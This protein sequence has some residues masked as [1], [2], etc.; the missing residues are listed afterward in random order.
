MC[1]Y[2]LNIVYVPDL[3]L[4]SVIPT[5]VD[6]SIETINTSGTNKLLVHVSK[7][8]NILFWLSKWV[9]KAILPTVTRI[10]GTVGTTRVVYVF[11]LFIITLV[12]K[13]ENLWQEY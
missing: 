8:S 6:L 3:F 11:S 9:F 7:T 12:R 1:S 10:L 13:D 5:S 2:S 4:Y